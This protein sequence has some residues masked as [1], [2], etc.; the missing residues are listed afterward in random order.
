MLTVAA[1]L[2]PATLYGF[3]LYGRPSIFLWV[4][5]LLA[6]LF[7]EAL[8]LKLVGRS[9]L[10]IVSDGSALAAV[11]DRRTRRPVRHH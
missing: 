2:L 4:I 8:C 5:T 10:P 11:V 9:V 7:G 3:W 1:K 6:A